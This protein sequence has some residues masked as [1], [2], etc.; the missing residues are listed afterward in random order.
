MWLLHSWEYCCLETSYF[1]ANLINRK[2][3]LSSS[4]KKK[5]AGILETLSSFWNHGNMWIIKTT[6]S[7]FFRL[8][9]WPYLSLYLNKNFTKRTFSFKCQGKLFC[10]FR[11]LCLGHLINEKDFEEKCTI[12]KLFS[13][14]FDQKKSF[15]I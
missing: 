6:K 9:L 13:I 10:C 15:F 3:N 11:L 2:V 1:S 14:W 12:L 7:T 8:C 4:E 5:A